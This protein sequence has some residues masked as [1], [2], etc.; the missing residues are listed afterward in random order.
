MQPNRHDEDYPMP[1]PAANS[2]LEVANWFF[3]KAEADGWYLEN[4]KLQHLLFL[5]QAHYAINNANSYLMP[6]AFVCD[7]N[8]FTEPGLQAALAFGRP[9]MGKAALP[10]EIN[11]FLSLIWQKYAPMSIRDLAA[12]IKASA[13]YTQ[14]YRPG[15]R[16]IV[17]LSDISSQ[18][19]G[20]LSGQ[21]LSRASAAKSKKILISQNGPVVV[22]EWQ[23]R[24]L[25]QKPKEN[26]HV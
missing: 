25:N 24:K 9:L 26:K 8:G 12:F 1:V 7:E 23:P 14:N 20:N 18:F 17:S 10:A 22:S 21:A 3:K 16:N 11:A 15:R 6:A 19:R 4:E 5:S 2:S 13:A